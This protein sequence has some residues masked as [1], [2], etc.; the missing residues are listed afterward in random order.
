MSFDIVATDP[1]E[2]KLKRLAK[3]YKSLSSD[4][5]EL[6][7]QLAEMPTMGDPLGKNCFKI[8]VTIASKGKGKRGGGRLITHVH[9]FQN[10]VYL[11]DIYDKSEQP[12]IS[13]RELK[14]L[15]EFLADD[16]GK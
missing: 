7:T 14:M 3:K 9:V 2:R 16:I 5:E 15:I 8:R 12:D 6:F 13:A 11:I 10:I 4:L 1:F